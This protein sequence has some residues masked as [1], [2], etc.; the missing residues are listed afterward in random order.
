MPRHS[1]ARGT[2]GAGVRQPATSCAAAL[3]SRYSRFVLTKQA[4]P[5]YDSDPMTAISAMVPT[6]PLSPARAALSAALAGESG[7]VG[8]M[9][10]I[11]VIGS[12]SYMGSACFVRTNREYRDERAAAQDVAG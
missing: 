7:S 5:M 9:A 6:E 4:D 1:T 3:S 11:A 2:R 12:E 8:T 10:E